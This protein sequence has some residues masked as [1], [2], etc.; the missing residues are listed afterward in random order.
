MSERSYLR[1]CRSCGK[2][3]A[4]SVNECP[5]CGKTLQSGFMLKLIIGLGC[6]ALAGAFAIP[7]SNDQYKD[8]QQILNTAVDHLNPADLANVFNT[9]PSRINHQAPRTA[10]QITGK[11]VQ[12]ELEVFVVT[13][14]QDHYKIVTK[15]TPSAPGTLLTVYPQNDRQTARLD[16]IRAGTTIE[17]RGKITGIQQGRIKI[18]PAVLI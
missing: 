17:I 12:W 4:K 5:H 18:N 14:S 3:F 7:T 2:D 9:S 16:T 13:K 10:N 11:I 15:P 1:N 6:L 8:R